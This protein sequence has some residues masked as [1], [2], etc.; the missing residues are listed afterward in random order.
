MALGAGEASVLARTAAV[1][2]V[3]L[4]LIAGRAGPRAYTLQWYAAGVVAGVTAL[5]PSWP[6]VLVGLV[7]L[8]AVPGL[9]E[10][11]RPAPIG[12]RLVATWGVVTG[13]SAVLAYAWWRWANKSASYDFL[14]AWVPDQKVWIAVAVVVGALANSFYEELLW[15]GAL[16]VG[17]RR[18]YGT[19]LASSVGFGLAHANGLPDGLAGVLLTFTLGLVLCWVV[20]HQKGRLPLAIATHVICDIVLLGAVSGLFTGSEASTWS[21]A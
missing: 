19:V 3:A 10:L 2:A 14:P 20:S 11:L 17:P 21:W 13:L 16:L 5:F 8:V 9:R 15:R 6:I 12:A 1:V 4:C 18:S 7:V